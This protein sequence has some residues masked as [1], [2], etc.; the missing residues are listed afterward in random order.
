LPL[1]G[2]GD[3]G[4]GAHSAGAERSRVLHHAGASQQRGRRL[5]NVSGGPPC[6]QGGASASVKAW[7][8]ELARLSVH[9]ITAQGPNYICRVCM[10]SSTC[11][12]GAWSSSMLCSARAT[13]S[14]RR[15]A[16]CRTSLAAGEARREAD[17]GRQ[18]R[19]RRNQHRRIISVLLRLPSAGKCLHAAAL[20]QPA[21]VVVRRLLQAGCLVT[22]RGP[23]GPR[24]LPALLCS[25]KD[26]MCWSGSH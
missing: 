17:S 20:H 6:L 8:C 25:V 22:R 15:R 13:H 26:D 24:S 21:C 18:Q 11:G 16:G 2:A 23:A 14:C 4:P 5:G 3:L 7:L 10:S 1:Q 9:S 19:R 12:A